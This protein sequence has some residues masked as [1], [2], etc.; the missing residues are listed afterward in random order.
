MG[1]HRIGIDENG[2]GARLGPLLVTGV[3][4]EVDERGT[5]LLRRKLP[6]KLRSDLDDSKRLVSCHD[7]S[8]GEA[9]ARALA[10]REAL[11]ARGAAPRTPTELFE[12]LSLEG[13]E[14]LMRPCPSEARPQCWEA[15]DESF[16]AEPEL[17]SRI[18][19]HLT[20]LETRGVRLLAVRCSTVCVAE[21]N[22]LKAAGVNR[23]C[24]DLHAME[25]LVLSL[26]E[27]AG[28][29][30]I[31][32]LGKV[33]GINEYGRFWGPLSGRLHNVLEEGRPR[34]AYRFPELGELSFVRDAD[35]VDP[36]VMLASLVGKYLR[37]L[38]MR[39]IG[40][41]WSAPDEALPSGYH[42]PVTQ[43]F[44]E[45]TALLRKRRGLPM[46]CFERSLDPAASP[47]RGRGRTA[48]TKQA[49][50][51]AATEPSSE[52]TPRRSA[53]DAGAPRRSRRVR[54]SS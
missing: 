20:F 30:V 27:H 5:R 29:E 54:T 4:A 32:T 37:E 22:R 11:V 40:R 39:R 1:V 12:Q 50:L 26:R 38:M 43:R 25:R 44:V 21:L 33:G 6:A 49:E 13:S 51:F 9:W 41:Y 36:L 14:R 24:A 46:N 23:F 47:S 18:Q 15:G 7:V 34:S 19:G 2:L 10:E 42:D 31:G 3:L 48:S 17:L 53:R 45:R 52:A 28:A 35:A 8:L 16:G